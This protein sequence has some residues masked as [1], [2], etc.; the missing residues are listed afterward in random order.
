[1]S[2]E[3]HLLGEVARKREADTRS[4]DADKA[5]ALIARLFQQQ[6]DFVLDESTFK[7]ALCPRRA[8]KSYALLVHALAVA[9]RQADSKVVIICRVRKQARGIYW[10]L[11]QKL[12]REFELG[13]NFRRLDLECELPNGSLIQFSGA[14]TQEEIEKLRGQAFDLAAID[15]CKSYSDELLTELID[16]VLTATTLDTLSGQIVLIGTPG[17]IPAGLFWSITTCQTKYPRNEGEDEAR[18]LTV[19][20]WAERSDARWKRRDY[21]WS[22]HAWTQKDN[23]KAPQVW[24]K[25]QVIKRKRNYTDDNPT[26]LREFMGKWAADVDA[27][28]FAYARLTDGR[29]DWIRDEAGPYGLPPGHGWRYLLGLD[30]GFHDDSAFVVAAWSDSFDKLVYLHVE[31]HAHLNIEEIANKC[32]ELEER[33]CG[34]DARVADTGG[35]GK[36]LVESLAAVYGVA[37]EAARK[38]EKHDHIKLLN[39]DMEE[40]RI[41]V[42]PTSPLAQEWRVA[43]WEDASRKRV[44]PGCADHASDAALYVWR[45]CHH[46]WFQPKAQGPQMGTPE[47]W[48]AK[49]REEEQRFAAQ[50]RAEREAP[51]W[52]RFKSRLDR[53]GVK[54]RW[55]TRQILRSLRD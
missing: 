47:W 6:R 54:E 23:V 26:W 3:L 42:D 46:H 10:Q 16:D 5:K 20:P 35:L 43:Q 7:A 22:F 8:G 51:S 37:F 32:K 2:R 1:M 30:L 18:D 33:Y 31:K 12:C 48:E 14:D 52:S 9:L 11:L 34:F 28:V 45:Y 19:R 25:A 13:A 17:P 21:E 41:W 55:T 36:T 39:A 29:C 53:G 40:G 27:L 24:E 15:E 38:T 44:D 49:E 50:V 4:R